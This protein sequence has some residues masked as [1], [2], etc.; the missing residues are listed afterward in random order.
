MIIPIGAVV[1]ESL[2]AAFAHVH[3]ARLGTP[4]AFSTVARHPYC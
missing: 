2:V 4:L 1:L 3:S